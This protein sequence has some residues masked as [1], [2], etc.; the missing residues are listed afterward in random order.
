MSSNDHD[1]EHIFVLGSNVRFTTPPSHVH[2]GTGIGYVPEKV[3]NASSSADQN[4]GW[5]VDAH[6]YE[7]LT[8]LLRFSAAHF[9]FLDKSVSVIVLALL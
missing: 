8:L 4:C 1:T 9:I 7:E 5:N 3:I 6:R 2:L